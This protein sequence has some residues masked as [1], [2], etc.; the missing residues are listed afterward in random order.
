M[1]YIYRRENNLNQSSKLELISRVDMAI[2][3][4]SRIL[5]NVYCSNLLICHLLGDLQQKFSSIGV[6]SRNLITES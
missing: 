1:N 4:I 2:D 6:F 3:P 5:C